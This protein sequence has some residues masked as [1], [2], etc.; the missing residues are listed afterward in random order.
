MGDQQQYKRRKIWIN[1]S[2]QAR[3]TAIIVGVAVAILVALGA[4][5]INTLNEQGRLM[6]VS[7]AQQVQTG[8]M[9]PDDAEFNR[10]LSG[11]V[12]SDNFKRTLVLAVIAALLVAA[13]VY[14]SV[15]MTFRAAGP[16]FAVSQM[17]KSMAAGNFRTIRPL[18]EKDE[19]RFLQDDIYLLRDSLSGA[20]KSD[21]G[22]LNRCAAA[23]ESPGDEAAKEGLAADIVEA[24][25]SREET[26]NL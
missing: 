5:Y 9:D 17:I 19:F 10:D 14:F 7:R 26:F 8:E 6:G 21:V 1:A 20:A 3:F 25:R 23:L 24:I 12:Q 11:E 16:V 22:L 2:F 18:R 4:L 15:R 13:L